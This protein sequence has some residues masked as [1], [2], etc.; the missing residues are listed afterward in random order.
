MKPMQH[1]SLLSIM[2]MRC[3]DVVKAV[4]DRI[5]YSLG[6]SQ[7]CFCQ[8]QLARVFTNMGYRQPISD[9]TMVLSESKDTDIGNVVSETDNSVDEGKAVNC[10]IC[11]F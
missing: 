4:G 3:P 2:C 8:K 5:I 11:I 10:Q 7:S 6:F 1:R 9:E